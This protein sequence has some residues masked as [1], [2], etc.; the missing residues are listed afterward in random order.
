MLNGSARAV[1]LGLLAM[2]A[3]VTAS[4][5]TSPPTLGVL[6]EQV[7]ALFPKIDGEVLEAQASAVT[8]SVGKRDG[9]VP[10][11]E[12]FLYREGRE[13]RHPKTG[14]VLG[15]TEQGV[16]R[17]QVQQVFEAYS[18]GT[19]TQGSGA[20]PGDKARV[21][22]GKIRLTLL[23]LAD[24]VKDGLVEAA[25]YELIEGLNRTGRFQIGMGDAVN[26]WLGQEG[27]KRQDAL[28]GKGLA[29]VGER[30][31]I[32]NLLVLH[33]KRVQNRPYMDV[34]LFTFPGASPVLTTALFVPASIKTTP[35]GDFSASGQGRESQTLK[36]QRSLLARLLAGDLD[37]GAYSSGESSIPLKEVAKFPFA[38]IAMDV[39]VSPQDKVP[40]LVVTDGERIYL[41]RFADRVL[42]PEW[43]YR[44][45]ARGR[46]FSVQLADLDGDGVFEV[47]ANR[48]HPN[49]A[50]LLTSVILTTKD[51]KPSVVAQ[52]IPEI[53]LAVDPTGEGVKRVLWGQEFV[54]NG[55]FKKGQA[56]RLSV[57]NGGIV[58]EGRVRVPSAFRA[59]AA[60]FAN[61][62]KDSRGLAFVDEYS[63][64]RVSVDG[65]D[66]WRS[67]TPVGGSPYKLEVM[68][69][70]ERGGRSFLYT[71]EPMPLAVDLDGDGIEE[72]VVVQ[73]QL[74]GR[75]AVVFKGPAGYRF[76][77]VNSGFEGTIMGLGAIPGDATPSLVAAVVRYYGT[78]STSGETQIIV[79]IPE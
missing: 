10:G 32:E 56:E 14:E 35:R 18:T 7:A 4:A 11:I 33:F 43:T 58:S 29:P 12:L 53:L 3:A 39:A 31:K 22:S 41:Y 6:V 19:V 61:L 77:T 15:R 66:A 65:E 70:I 75:L 34:R 16:G 46:V 74:P 69:Q 20:R 60:T 26:V 55:F 2:A 21:S 17:A 79:T 57:R 24:G 9:V 23:P 78:I 27:I 13:L 5:Q 51:R 8:L 47:V 59:I 71:V 72:V 28:E 68:T 25:V 54:Q 49:P 30:F 36:P 63:R 42:E 62:G 38:V 40:R 52:D 37:A 45:D 48:Y 1:G 76:Q 67:T 50:I 64:L 73:N 44:G